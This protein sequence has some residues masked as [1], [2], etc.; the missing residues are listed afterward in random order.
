MALLRGDASE[1]A[2]RHIVRPNILLPT[3]PIQVNGGIL[4]V[5]LRCHVKEEGSAN[6]NDFTGR[7]PSVIYAAEKPPFGNDGKFEQGVHVRIHDQCLTSEVFGSKRYDIW[8]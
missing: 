4:P 7:E 6:G 2:L 1:D 5:D 3:L 8:T